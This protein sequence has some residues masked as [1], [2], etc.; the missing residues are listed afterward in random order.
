M[1]ALPICALMPTT[2]TD[3]QI[4]LLLAER[5]KQTGRELIRGPIHV[6]DGDNMVLQFDPT[7]ESHWGENDQAHD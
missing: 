2:F 6:W 7:D 4:A 5:S 3:Q 1:R